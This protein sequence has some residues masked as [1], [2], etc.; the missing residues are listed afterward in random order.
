[1]N[2]NYILSSSCLKEY[3]KRAYILGKRQ[4]EKQLL[5]KVGNSVR[6]PSG[7]LT[8]FPFLLTLFL[9]VLG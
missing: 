1:M 4:P 7:L 3:S 9:T 2:I 8:I 5:G 6:I